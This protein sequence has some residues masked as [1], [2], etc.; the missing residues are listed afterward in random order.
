MC[1][2]RF[3]L[4]D[5]LFIFRALWALRAWARNTKKTQTENE[6]YTKTYMLYYVCFWGFIIADLLKFNEFQGF[7]TAMI[8][9]HETHT[10]HVRSEWSGRAH[11]RSCILSLP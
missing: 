10:Q 11:T 3:V 1:C 7:H 2:I 8:L 4:F 6:T 9:Q 5:M